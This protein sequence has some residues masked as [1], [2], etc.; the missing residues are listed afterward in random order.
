MVC[1][2]NGFWP[3]WGSNKWFP[4]RLLELQAFH[5]AVDEKQRS[6]IDYRRDLRIEVE[7]K[8]DNQHAQMAIDGLV[9]RY[10][11]QFSKATG[12]KWLLMPKADLDKAHKALINTQNCFASKA[13]LHANVA[14]DGENEDA[15]KSKI[16]PKSQSEKAAIEKRDQ[17]EITA[18][19]A[20]IAQSIV[21]AVAAYN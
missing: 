6:L 15:N 16:T 20:A 21:G 1:P 3:F 19:A 4:S 5:Y 2:Q 8:L 12:G 9:V 7:N 14:D 18:N 11:K 17:A 10:K 13:G